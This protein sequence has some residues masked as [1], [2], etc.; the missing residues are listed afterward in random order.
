MQDTSTGTALGKAFVRGGD[1]RLT[2][3][4]SSPKAHWLRMNAPVCRGWQPVRAGPS[5]RGAHSIWAPL[6]LTCQGGADRSAGRSRHDVAARDEPGAP[7]VSLCPVNRL[8]SGLT[9]LPNRGPCSKR[10][11]GILDRWMPRVSRKLAETQW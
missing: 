4:T 2:F 1:W 9:E 6:S 3:R 7:A 10:W 11:S 5:P 8:W